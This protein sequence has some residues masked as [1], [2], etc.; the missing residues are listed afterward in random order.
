MIAT[1]ADDPAGKFELASHFVSVPSD[2][3]TCPAEPKLP[4]PSL[5]WPSTSKI[6][7][8]AIPVTLVLLNVDV[9]E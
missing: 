8:V 5:N 7:A 6:A 3:N 2:V 9:P 1:F 4:S